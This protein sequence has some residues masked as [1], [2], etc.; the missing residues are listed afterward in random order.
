VWL[1][2]LAST[3]DENAIAEATMTALGLRGSDTPARDVLRSH[4]GRRDTLL[5]FDNCEHVLGGAA[6]LIAELLATCPLMRVIATS[7]EP[8]RVPGEEEYAIEGLGREEAIDLFAER[9]PGQ[10]RIDDPDAIGRICVGLEG[11]PLAI[12]LAAAKLRVL[13]PAA[14]ADRLDD[15]LAVLAHGSRTAPRRQRTLRATLDWSYDLL[16]E[17]ERAVSGALESSPKALLRVP[18]SKSSPTIRSLAL[19]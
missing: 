3:D 15:Q 8:L 11:I 18:L 1:V 17:D 13:S 12:E 7:R 19:A 16:D 4:L 10:S 2:E 5:L 9:V 14:L 6:T